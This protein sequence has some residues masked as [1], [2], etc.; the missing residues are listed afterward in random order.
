MHSPWFAMAK[1]KSS[2]ETFAKSPFLSNVY[3]SPVNA[4]SMKCLHLE[5]E[6]YSFGATLN[7]SETKCQNGYFIYVFCSTKLS[8]DIIVFKSYWLYWN[9]RHFTYINFYQ[10]L[11]LY[12]NRF[13]IIRLLYERLL[14]TGYERGG[15]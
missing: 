2:F 11:P 12:L 8:I 14:L 3:A 15:N 1:R 7:S 9:F 4:S 5:G 13:E 6:G 10:K